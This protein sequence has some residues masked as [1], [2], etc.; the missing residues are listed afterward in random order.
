ML[1]ELDQP[2]LVNISVS[3]FIIQTK[4]EDG[5]AVVFY[6]IIC[7]FHIP[8]DFLHPVLIVGFFFTSSLTKKNGDQRCLIINYMLKSRSI[9]NISQ[10]MIPAALV[11][12]LCLCKLNVFGLDEMFSMILWTKH[13][14][15]N[16]SEIHLVVQIIQRSCCS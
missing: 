12:I 10:L 11:S 5:P 7:L 2:D 16:S 8:A 14:F 4:E 1:L 9:T 15:K 3:R 13:F 6:Q